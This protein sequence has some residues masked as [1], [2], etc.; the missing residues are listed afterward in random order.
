[1]YTK[2]KFTDGQIFALVFE[3]ETAMSDLKMSDLLRYQQTL[4]EKHKNDW[5]PHTP[6]FGRDSL[7]WCIDEIGEVI[8][9]I[10]KKG[11]YGK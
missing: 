4:L 5:N 2:S 9:I 1:M 6:E 10:K 3:G 8:A 7:L 11:Y